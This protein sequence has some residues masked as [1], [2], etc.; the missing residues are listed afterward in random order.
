MEH[1][2][3]RVRRDTQNAQ[4]PMISNTQYDRFWPMAVVGSETTGDA[5]GGS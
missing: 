5:A 4:I 3:D 2:R 1:T